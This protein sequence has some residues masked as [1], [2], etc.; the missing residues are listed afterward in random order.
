MFIGKVI[1]TLVAT[2][3]DPSLHG[4]KLMIVQPLDEKGEA[5]GDPVVATDSIGIGVGE[6]GFCV[7]GREATLALPNAFAP[8][9]AGIVGIVDRYDVDL[10]VLATLHG[11]QTAIQGG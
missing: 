6:L 5:K 9:D 3:K 7:N 10:E 4:V 1:G 8:V 2:E 11:K